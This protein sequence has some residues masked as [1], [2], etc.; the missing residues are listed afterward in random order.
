MAP[1]IGRPLIA[2]VTLPVIAAV[3]FGSRTR[4]GHSRHDDARLLREEVDRKQRD[5]DRH[6][7]APCQPKCRR[8]HVF[9][10]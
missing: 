9:P 5:D 1:A 6:T 8:C 7:R 10:V 3:P 4:I 2:S